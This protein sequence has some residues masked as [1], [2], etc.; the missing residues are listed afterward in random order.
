VTDD[1]DTS[2]R[3]N[4]GTFWGKVVPVEG[5][6]ADPRYLDVFGPAGQRKILPVETSCH[7]FACVFDGSG[8]FSDASGPRPVQTDRVGDVAGTSANLIGNRSL[9]L[10]ERG[11]EVTVKEFDSCWCRA[12]RSR[13]RSRGTGLS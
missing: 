13:N 10:C 1:D 11:D 2:V 8:N 6:A 4:C 9:M 5:V 7:A 3:V 12:S